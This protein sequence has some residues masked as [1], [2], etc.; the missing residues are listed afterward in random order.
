MHRSS[1]LPSSRSRLRN[2]LLG[3]L[4]T[5]RQKSSYHQL[6]LP[7]TDLFMMDRVARGH[8]Q[9]NRRRIATQTREARTRTHHNREEMNRKGQLEAQIIRSNT[10][11]DQNNLLLNHGADLVRLQQRESR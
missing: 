11:R 4:Q 8:L 3:L 7:V 6:A 10:L 9:R 1:A 2:L 5:S